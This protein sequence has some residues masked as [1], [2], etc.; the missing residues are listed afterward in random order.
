MCSSWALDTAED[1][2]EF[3]D[4]IG[5]TYALGADKGA[6]IIRD[7]QVTSFPTTVFLDEEHRIVS[8]W[9]GILTAGKLEVRWTPSVGQDWGDIK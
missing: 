2:Q 1:G 5:V 9:G 6:S 8:E 4:E 3:V 7:F